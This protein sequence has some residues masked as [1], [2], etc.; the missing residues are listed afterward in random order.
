[1]EPLVA[2]PA[3]EWLRSR[4]A[5]LNQRFALVAR[6]YPKLDAELALL[7]LAEVLPVMAGDGR[8]PA[9][10]DLL[11]ATYDL[12][13]LHVARGTAGRPAI[14]RL[15]TTTLPALR[16]LLLQ[17]PGALPAALSN[18]VEQV[19]ADETAYCQLLERLS[20]VVASPAEL[21]DAGAVAAWRCGRAPLRQAALQAM[22]RLPGRAVLTA[23]EVGDWPEASAGLVR[24]ALGQ[25]A[26]TPLKWRFRDETLEQVRRE[27]AVP[28]AV[29]QALLQPQQLR[30]RIV[31][32][33]G[34]WQGFGG[35]FAQPPEVIAAA[36]RHSLA[37]RVDGKMVEVVA[38]GFGAV[39]RSAEDRAA[40]PCK[41]LKTSFLAH[42]LPAS[43]GLDDKGV[44]HDS[45]GP[46]LLPELAGAASYSLKDGCL[47]VA[48]PDSHRLRIAVRVAE[49]V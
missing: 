31:A 28:P 32:R 24:T 8:D 3:E 6:R 37:V 45:S 49:A 15:L 22:A 25:D 35:P 13:L 43:V 39:F 27:G 9:T 5:E 33:V 30:W 11:A 42:L 16:P 7:T 36:D 21:L 38:D 40:T 18:A 44:V 14:A 17:R 29:A 12:V 48:L 10:A 1:M 46:T 4:R 2:G 47:A 34:A 23:L 19:G 20:G 41:P 26:W